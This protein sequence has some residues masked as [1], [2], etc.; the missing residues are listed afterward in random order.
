[1]KTVLLA[2]ALT[3]LATATASAGP[4]PADRRWPDPAPAAQPGDARGATTA[5]DRLVDLGNRFL[6]EPVDAISH[7]AV[8]VRVDTQGA[9]RVG[10]DVGRAKYAELNVAIRIRKVTTIA[11]RM[12]PRFQP[13]PGRERDYVEESD[14]AARLSSRVTL[15]MAGR[16]VELALPALEVAPAEHRGTRGVE[17]RIPLVRRD[18]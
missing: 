2:L 6:S 14:S 12:P 4:V 16:S 18:F 15:A 10:V 8:S 17:L 5:K 3:L 9:A 1:M 13:E 7:R 11:G